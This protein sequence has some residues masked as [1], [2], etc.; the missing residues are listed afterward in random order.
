MKL[1]GVRVEDSD[2]L[3]SLSKVLDKEIVDI[4]GY[5]S[6]KFDLLTFKPIKV[7]FVDGTDMYFEG[8]QDHPY[9]VA[10]GREDHEQFESILEYLWSESGY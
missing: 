1:E 6:N 4:Q 8:E 3:L 9:V 7:V 5:I 2:Y 10:Y